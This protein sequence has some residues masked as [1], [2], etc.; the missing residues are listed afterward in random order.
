M[1]RKAGASTVCS[2]SWNYT[3]P[4]SGI[5]LYE[6]LEYAAQYNCN[7]PIGDAVFWY[8]QSASSTISTIQ[9]TNRAWQCGTLVYSHPNGVAHTSG[10]SDSSPQLHYGSSCAAQGDTNGNWVNYGPNF[11]VTHY[12]NY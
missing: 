1:I 11:N 12:M 5:T 10:I 4:V 8:Y 2:Q 9:T 6:T 7:P 3:E